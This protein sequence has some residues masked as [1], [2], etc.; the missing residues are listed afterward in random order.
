MAVKSMTPLKAS[1]EDS[2][3]ALFFQKYWHIV[4]DEVSNFCL[5][6]FNGKKSIR[7]INSTIIMLLPKVN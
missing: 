1:G 7:G 5:E 4:G 2:F 6:V 3:P